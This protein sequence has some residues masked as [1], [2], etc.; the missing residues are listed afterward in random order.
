MVRMSTPLGMPVAVSVPALPVEITPG[1]HYDPY[2]KADQCH[3]GDGADP[4]TEAL[5]HSDARE[6]NDG[7]DR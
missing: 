2:S 5:R 7:S 4:I 6:P 1:G 3:A